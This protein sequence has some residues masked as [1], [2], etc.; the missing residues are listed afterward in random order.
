M[1]R[2]SPNFGNMF[3]LPRFWWTLQTFLDGPTSGCDPLWILVVYT[4]LQ[5]SSQQIMWRLMRMRI[6]CLPPNP[7]LRIKPTYRKL[8]HATT[9]DNKN[10]TIS[11]LL[12][13]FYNQ[14]YHSIWKYVF[15]LI[16]F[17]VFSRNLIICYIRTASRCNKYLQSKGTRW[18]QSTRNC[19]KIVNLFAFLWTVL[20]IL[21]YLKHF[22]ITLLSF[23]Y[24]IFSTYIKRV[25]HE[26]YNRSVSMLVVS[27][28]VAYIR[29]LYQYR[30]R[31]T[32]V[33]TVI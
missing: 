7:F 6:I 28:A 8:T 25:Q 5:I 22:D 15:I 32:H 33:D 4:I 10:K 21:F 29:R 26:Y 19:W 17:S 27:H 31:S 24:S 18:L 30:P 16:Y 23:L 2:I 3:F 12:N 13:L 1:S 20:E 9:K 11:G 14:N